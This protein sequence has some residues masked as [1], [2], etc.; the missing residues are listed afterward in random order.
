VFVFPGGRIPC[1]LRRQ[2]DYFQLIGEAYVY[3]I[4]N[5]EA[6]RMCETGEVKEESIKL[7]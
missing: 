2:G 1:V 4:M 5:G 7:R 6:V 3:G